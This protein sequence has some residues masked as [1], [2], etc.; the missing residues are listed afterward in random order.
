MTAFD[1]QDADAARLNSDNVFIGHNIFTLSTLFNDYVEA[2]SLSA[3]SLS[4]QSEDFIIDDEQSLRDLSLDIYDKVNKNKDDINFLSNVISTN[5]YLGSVD[6]TEATTSLSAWFA[7]PNGIDGSTKLHPGAFARSDNAHVSLTDGGTEKFIGANDY[8]VVNTDVIVSDIK[9]EHIDF[10]YDSK[11]ES[12]KLSN[13][14]SSLSNEMNQA[15]SF[16]N[17]KIDEVALSLA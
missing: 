11:N 2:S 17:G 9:W 4:V 14:L 7:A 5:N 16:L 12:Y 3:G 6:L 13:D 10:I 15:S 1:A 8:L